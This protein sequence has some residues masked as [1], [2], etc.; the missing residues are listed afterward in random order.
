DTARR[1]GRTGPPQRRALGMLA[2][3]EGHRAVERRVDAAAAVDRA[4][5]YG[6]GERLARGAVGRRRELEARRGRIGPPVLEQLP[7]LAAHERGER[8]DACDEAGPGGATER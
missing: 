6:G 2:Q 7:H 1:I 5:S 4:D 8:Q 3:R